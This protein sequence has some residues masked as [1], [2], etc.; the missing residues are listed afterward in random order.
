MEPLTVVA[1]EIRNPLAA[2]R[3]ALNI[4]AVAETPPHRVE[5]V[6]LMIE[7]QLMHITRVVDLLVSSSQSQAIERRRKCIDLSSVLR[8]AAEAC[9]PKIR[10][11][12]QKLTVTLADVPMSVKGDTT[13]LTQVFVNLLDNAAKFSREGEEIELSSTVI[14]RDVVVRVQ[15]S[16][17]GIAEGRLP[18]ALS[19]RPQDFEGQQDGGLGIG[20]VLVRRI[21][22][23]HGGTIE[24]FSA[25][26]AQGSTFIVRIPLS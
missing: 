24:A 22:E 25:G 14:D 18:D 13:S 3:N 1:H 6:R 4:L 8:L 21:V 9:G 26:E 7:R 11:R 2:I 19:I 17:V 20:L 15:D 23:L 10:A 12:H 5:Q 16:G